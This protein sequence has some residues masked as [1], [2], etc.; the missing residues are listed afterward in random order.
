MNARLLLLTLGIGLASAAMADQVDRPTGPAMITVAG[1]VAHSNRGPS[2]PEDPTVLGALDIR[3]DKAMRFDSAMLA[4]LPQSSLPLAFPPGADTV[5]QFSG[6]TL[7]SV[8]QAAGAEG[9][10]A[11]VVGLDGYQVDITPDLINDHDPI[12]ATSRDGHPLDIGGLGP[13]IVV[14]PSVSDLDLQET[15]SALQVWGV[16]LI[17]AR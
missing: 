9:K 12:V 1:A 17:Q 10:T 6:P 2:E 14:F 8:L 15:L 3:F 7:A 4:A 5:S 11:L 16:F 13:A